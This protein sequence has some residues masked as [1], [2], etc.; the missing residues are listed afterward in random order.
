M[1]YKIVIGK[2]DLLKKK[3]NEI[4]RNKRKIQRRKQKM[5]SNLFGKVGGD[6]KNE[7]ETIWKG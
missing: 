3:P 2:E 7:M 6:L 1:L 5:K 4:K